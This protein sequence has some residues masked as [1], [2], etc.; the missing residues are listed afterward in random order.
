MANVAKIRPPITARP[1]GAF[2][3]PPSPRAS[4][5]SNVALSTSTAKRWQALLADDAVSHQDS[6][7]KAGDLATKQSVVNALQA[8]V[9]RYLA[10]KQ[11]TR[12]VVPFDGVVTSRSTDVGALINVVGA[13]G[14]E[15]F[16]R[17]WRHRANSVFPGRHLECATAAS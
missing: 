2:C 10:L 6:D 11:F 15:L 7:E 1:S 12:I 13:P 9:E 5:K 16:E 3:S 8:N 4:A 14:S 17:Q